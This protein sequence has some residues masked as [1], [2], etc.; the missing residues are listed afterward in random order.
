M[1]ISVRSISDPEISTSNKTK[2]PNSPFFDKLRTFIRPNNSIIIAGYKY[3]DTPQINQ[4]FDDTIRESQQVQE[5][6]PNKNNQITLD[7]SANIE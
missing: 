4:S 7:D 1:N 2:N 6:L 5:E 3:N